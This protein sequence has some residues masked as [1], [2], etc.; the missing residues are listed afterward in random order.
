MIVK[1]NAIFYRLSKIQIFGS[2]PTKA[3]MSIIG[4]HTGGNWMTDSETIKQ[5]AAGLTQILCASR[6]I[7]FEVPEAF[8]DGESVDLPIEDEDD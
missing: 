1:A 7:E 5:T 4:L 6:G 8:A 2:F 3:C